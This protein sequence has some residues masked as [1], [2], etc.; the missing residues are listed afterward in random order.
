MSLELMEVE[1]E[2][3]TEMPSAVRDTINPRHE[4]KFKCDVADCTKDACK[5]LGAGRNKRSGQ[6]G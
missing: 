3:R 5:F 2:G 4:P 6:Q 1:A